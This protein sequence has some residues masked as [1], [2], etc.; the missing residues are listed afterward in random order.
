MSTAREVWEFT[1]KGLQKITS[2]L[3]DTG[4]AMDRVRSSAST[5]A[6]TLGA[7][8]ATEV[9]RQMVRGANM[10]VDAF[11]LQD[12]ALAQV[13]QG[14]LTTNGVAQRSFEELARMASAL[15][16]QSLFE[17]DAI[18]QDVTAQLLTFTNI[19]GDNFDRTQVAALDLAQRLGGDLKGAAIQLGK[20][21]NDPVANL[22]ALSR[23]GIQFSEQQK[24]VIAGL[25]ATNR[26]ADAQTI[27]LDEL[28][29]QYGGSAYA[30][31]QTFSGELKQMQNALGD[32][33]EPLGQ[34]LIP[35]IIQ[36]TGWVRD[37]AVPALV[38]FTGWLSKNRDVIVGVA[39]TIGIV[40]AAMKAWQ[41]ITL[42]VAA[43]QAV[44]KLV[45]AGNPIFLFAMA[46]IALIAALAWLYNNVAVVRKVVD[47]MLSA[48][49]KFYNAIY[50][51]IWSGLKKFAD[52]MAN[53]FGKLFSW[54]AEKLGL[55]GAAAKDLKESAD[56]NFIGP[57]APGGPAYA[58]GN[59]GFQ[60]GLSPA[61]IAALINGGGA[62][63]GGGGGGAGGS[64]NL[65]QGIS[66]ITA[67]A[68]K[69]FNI[70]IGSLIEEL[71][72]QTTN[73]RDSESRIKEVVTRAMLSAINDTQTAV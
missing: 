14:V 18:L 31:T 17:D 53:T 42:V 37:N 21:L 43:A 8:G 2:D 60:A 51:P 22:S 27:I 73:L 61:E 70:N 40:M 50:G 6:G 13:R 69:V 49:W 64:K 3:R 67:A 25:V 5:F 38:M 46:V 58:A 29:T 35:L 19:V 11:I 48:W 9:F 39:A 23:S 45:M 41:I 24:D 4:G 71:T 1:A 54:I 55:A 66:E 44:L 20:A 34:E 32:S 52:W 68:P 63:G 47:F 56:A 65:K 15:Q 16:D 10:A 7:L 30:A 36:F 57:P 12:Q 62:S 26:L 72:F 33:L 59:S 28:A